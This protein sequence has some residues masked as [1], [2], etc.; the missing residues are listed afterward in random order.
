[1]GNKLP[2]DPGIPGG[3]GTPKPEIPG[4][5]TNNELSQAE[6]FQKMFN[7][8]P[9]RTNCHLPGSPLIPAGPGI[10]SLPG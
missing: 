3:P 6:H 7:G 1:M 5:D 2:G 8:H 9:H 4:V 10:P